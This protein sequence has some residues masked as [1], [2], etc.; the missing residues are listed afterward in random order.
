LLGVVVFILF[1]ILPDFIQGK[2]KQNKFQRDKDDNKICT[3]AHSAIPY[4]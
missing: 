3:T 2:R 1:G 4:A